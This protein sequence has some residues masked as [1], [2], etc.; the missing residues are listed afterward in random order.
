[1]SL[2]K[3]FLIKRMHYHFTRIWLALTLTSMSIS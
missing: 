2:M 1:M 3:P